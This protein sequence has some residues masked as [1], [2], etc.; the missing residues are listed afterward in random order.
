MENE[1]RKIKQDLVTDIL[2][3][4]CETI[5]EMKKGDLITHQTMSGLIKRP[6]PATG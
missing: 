6:Y 3:A 5:S 4:A 1:T 2:D